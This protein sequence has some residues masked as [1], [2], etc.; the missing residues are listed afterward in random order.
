[1]LAHLYSGQDDQSLRNGALALQFASGPADV[2]IPTG[3]LFYPWQ[4]RMP[5]LDNWTRP[6]LTLIAP[7][8]KAQKR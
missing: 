7:D 3:K 5:L 2:R 8:K 4:L 6:L 1:M